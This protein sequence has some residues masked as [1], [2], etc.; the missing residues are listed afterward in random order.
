MQ[1]TRLLNFFRAM[2][3]AIVLFAAAGQV[4]AGVTASISGTVTDTSG[5]AVVGATVT[6]T[7]V[8]TAIAYTQ[9]T[10]G[11]GYYSF[12]VLP[13]GKYTVEVQQTGFKGYRQ[14]NLILDVNAALVVDVSLQVGQATEKV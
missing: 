9:H 4:F 7:N 13:L 6:A 3:V 11:Q 12:Q 8:D 14:T 1:A 10:N 2:V 5:A